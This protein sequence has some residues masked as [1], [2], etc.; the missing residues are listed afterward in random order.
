[1]PDMCDVTFVVGERQVP[2]HAVRAILATRSR[3]FYDLILKH[4]SMND[5]EGKV[6]CKKIK[7]SKDKSK[8]GIAR[9][10]SDRL[11][12]PVKST[13]PSRFVPW[14]S[15]STVVLSVSQKKP[16]QIYAVLDKRHESGHKQ[17]SRISGTAAA[18][19]KTY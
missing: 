17:T 16:Y 3:I 6:N 13:T 10:C 7:K 4:I 12:I 15:S 2:F 14:S 5:A 9:Q 18:M 19:I 11:V 8:F 1:M